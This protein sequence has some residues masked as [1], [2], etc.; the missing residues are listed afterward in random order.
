MRRFS[1]AFSAL[2]LVLT[3][4]LPFAAH[5]Q[6]DDE[7]VVTAAKAIKVSQGGA[8]DIEFFKKSVENG[9]MPTPSAITAEGL[10]YNY[11]L[12]LASNSPCS[13]LF[14]LEAETME[15][16]MIV[17][18][19]IDKL[20]GLGFTTKLT[21]D[22]WQRE[23]LTIVAVVDKSGSMRGKPMEVAKASMQEVLKNLRAGD[24][25]AV[26]EYGSNTRV[27]VPVTDVATGRANLFSGIDSIRQGGYTSM[28]AG[29][30]LAYDTAF[31]SQAGYDGSTRV[32]LFTDEQP[33]VGATDSASFIGMAQEASSKGVGMT[34]IGVAE[35][36]GADLANKVSAARGGNLFYIREVEDVPK[37]LGG[38]FDLIMTELAHDLKV[39]AKPAKGVKIEEVYGVPG[40]DIKFGYS[41]SIEFTI[42][43]VFLSSE[44]GG[45]FLGVSGDGKDGSFIDV[46][47]SYVDAR[48]DE[49]FESSLEVASVTD[50][51]STGLKRAHALV[52]EFL[53]VREVTQAKFFGEDLSQGQA[54][55]Q[56]L[57]DDL[58]RDPQDP[59]YQ[60]AA[61][62]EDYAEL[63]EQPVA[64]RKSRHYAHRNSPVLGKWQVT[65]VRKQSRSMFG[66]GD[67]D[68]RKGDRIAF[69][70]DS[71]R[72]DETEIFNLRRDQPQRG[73][74][75]FE[76]ES[77][78]VDY[79]SQEIF[80]YDSD[81]KFD[82][83]Q[84]GDRLF[85]YPEDTQLVLVLEPG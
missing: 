19:E 41:G 84:K 55:V 30:R 62:I 51:P 46:D 23:P 11:D 17:P 64:P 5:A 77:F 59:I 58:V 29:L 69:H 39:K 45:I 73:E 76:S 79:A 10:L 72:Y 14:C 9:Y 70:L 34:T 63:L 32:V 75:K 81:I 26:V 33:N 68:I 24:R 52:N 56:A 28:E 66:N 12:T 3:L 57:H 80:L 2:S 74:A 82:Y 85:L 18:S 27:V 42:P 43:S 7:I 20:V 22:T 21:H 47:M 8:A 35:H 54:Y 71:D 53:V 40:E 83:K 65:K 15:A 13:E 49:K 67:I 6:E 36:F 38:D 31:K 60:E 1:N 16:D 61:F 44:G 25:M 4:A 50:T 48:T 78:G 37:T